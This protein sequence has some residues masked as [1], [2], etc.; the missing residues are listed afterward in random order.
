MTFLPQTTD[1]TLVGPGAEP[2]R[3]A[4]A[5][6][7]LGEVVRT[8]SD[9]RWAMI[10][11][12]FTMAVTMSAYQPAPV[13]IWVD[14]GHYIVLARAL[15]NGQGYR[16]L[17]L[18]GQP[19]GTHFPPGYPALLAL[20]SQFVPQ[21]PANIRA[22]IFANA[23]LAAVIAF[24]VVLVAHRQLRLSLPVA[25]CAGAIW[26]IAVPSL[27]LTT[28][29]LSEPLFLAVLLPGLLVAERAARV[30]GARW[31][32]AACLLL[33]LS[34]MVRSIGIAA[35]GAFC[36]VL[37]TRRRWR[38]LGL[39]I[40]ACV[41]MLAPWSVWK[42]MH[43]SALPAAWAGMYGDYG[44][45]L[46]RGVTSKGL[47]LLV[48]VALQNARDTVEAF[49]V[50]WS[51]GPEGTFRIVVAVALMLAIGLGVLVVR[52]RAPVIVWT[53]IGYLAIVMVWP[54]H[55]QRFIWGLGALMIPCGAAGVQW[56]WELVRDAAPRRYGPLATG[57]L[58]AVALLIPAATV[59]AI[60]ERD[61]N[62]VP[63][64]GAQTTVP[65]LR[66]I[67]RNTP[68]DAL[69]ACEAETAVYLYT[70]RQAVPF[71]PF[72]AADRVG[73]MTAD[74]AYAGLSEILRRYRPRWVCAIG[75]QSLRVATHFT[76]HEGA[77]LRMV[78]VPAFGAVF[79]LR[80]FSG[81][82]PSPAVIQAR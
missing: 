47:S 73:L 23:V 17:N 40:P 62:R 24:G 80:A 67:I 2:A 25:A 81:A 64:G 27:M 33:A 52:R 72:K 6:T 58:A 26:A 41:A 61:W 60:P 71:V 1:E 75:V 56:V 44:D 63:G 57:G 65:M 66:W 9:R 59:L 35:V 39:A 30:G 37:A 68:P 77:P 49:A 7:R 79:E 11:A 46:A 29:V 22:F 15:A 70:G 76:T 36:L 34:A 12:A 48:K 55:P 54:F 50:Y 51:K 28:A 5:A 32:F 3:P 43:K 78:A 53:I 8:W 4:S 69:L 38:E 16:Y 10:V 19:Y 13:G 82:A 45:W 21:F 14:D 42:Q 18:P 31:T 74:E 20:I